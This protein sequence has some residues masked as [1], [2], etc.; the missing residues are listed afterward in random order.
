MAFWDKPVRKKKYK[1]SKNGR[2]MKIR[3]MPVLAITRMI[4]SPKTPQR[5]KDFWAKELYK[6][7]LVKQPILRSKLK[8]VV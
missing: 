4:K 2:R 3:G 7:G 5:L 1:K 8:R 6:K